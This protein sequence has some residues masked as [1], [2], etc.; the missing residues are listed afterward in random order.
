MVNAQLVTNAQNRL[1]KEMDLQLTNKIAVVTGGTRGIGR[2]ISE[3]LVAEGAHVVVASRTQASVNE[4]IDTLGPSVSGVVADV[5][6]PNDLR[7]IADAVLERH[8][9]CDILINNAGTGT[10]KPFLDVTDEDLQYGMAINFFAQFRL[11]QLLVPSMMQRAGGVI[12]NISGRTAIRTAHP[13]GSTCTG[14]AKA[15]ELRFTADL[16]EELKPHG[17]RVVCIVPGVVMTPDRFAKWER[18]ATGRD[19][20]AGEAGELRR[21]LERDKLPPGATWGTPQQIADI[22]TFVASPRASYLSGESI[23]VDGSPGS[24]SYVRALYESSPRPS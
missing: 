21:E 1:D 4:T 7:R 20:T 13:P 3:T 5:T 6:K 16:A 15:A 17:I 23:L 24:Y 11:S 19:L 8:G 10:Y 9:G 22:T 2:A 14:P 12:V 18:E